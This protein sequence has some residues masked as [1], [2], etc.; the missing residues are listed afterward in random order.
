[1]FYNETVSAKIAEV[2]IA[3]VAFYN[4][5][6]YVHAVVPESGQNFVCI[7]FYCKESPASTNRW[8]IIFVIVKEDQNLIAVMCEYTQI[9]M[10]ACVTY[11]KYEL[12]LNACTGNL[13]LQGLKT[14]E[15]LKDAVDHGPT[16]PIVFQVEQVDFNGVETSV[17]GWEVKIQPRTK[18]VSS[19][20]FSSGFFIAGMVQSY[21]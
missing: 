18:R 2:M 13:H 4:M 3:S 15:D 21:M 9:S 1:M 10:H 16:T 11:G 19:W 12:R 5:G 17:P 14:K 8:R 6:F 7:T 20:I